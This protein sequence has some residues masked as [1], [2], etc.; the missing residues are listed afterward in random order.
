MKQLVRTTRPK[1]YFYAQNVNMSR[2]FDSLH[3]MAHDLLGAEPEVGDILICD[4]HN[5]TKRK[6]LQKTKTGYMIYYGRLDDT[7]KFEPLAEND[8]Q[9]KRLDKEVL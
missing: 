8:G 3:K 2:S 5:K 9:L 1:R 6:M 7:T 4:N